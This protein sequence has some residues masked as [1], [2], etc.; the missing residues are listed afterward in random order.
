MNLPFY[1]MNPT[2]VYVRKKWF[3]IIRLWMPE[4]WLGYTYGKPL[5]WMRSN[6][7]D[8]LRVWCSLMI[9]IPPKWLC[10]D[11]NIAIKCAIELTPFYSS[12]E[13]TPD[14][15]SWQDEQG[16][17]LAMHWIKR[18]SD[19]PL[20]CLAHDPF[21]KNHDGQTCMDLW[22]IRFPSLSQR[23]LYPDLYRECPKWMIC[24]QDKP[25]QTNE[26]PLPIE[27]IFSI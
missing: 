22:N 25:E 3:G 26:E 19:K 2:L 24:T 1:Q 12:K 15:P 16:N 18:R 11:R 8:L 27:D 13:F 20:K 10:S 7:P 14:D 5:H 23:L 21:I 17:T 9:K 6:T 4:Q